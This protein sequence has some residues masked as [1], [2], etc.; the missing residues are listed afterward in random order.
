MEMALK[1]SLRRLTPKRPLCFNPCDNGN[2]SKSKFDATDGVSV[3]AGFNP[4]DNGNGSKSPKSYFL[5]VF[6]T[7]F[8]PCDN[9]NG[10]KSINGRR[11]DDRRFFVSI[12]VI[13]E[14]ALKDGLNWKRRNHNH[15]FQS[16]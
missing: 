11:R 13:M 6:Q 15:K 9:G 3:F 16:L 1:E 14:M 7:S 12:L 10:S 2:G 5:H 8:N 4:C